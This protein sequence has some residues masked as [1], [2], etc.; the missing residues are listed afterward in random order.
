MGDSDKPSYDME[1]TGDEAKIPNYGDGETLYERLGGIY[2]IAG[3][4]DVL[5][6]R[7]FEND[8]ANQ[9]PITAEFHET[10]DP[11]GFKYLVTA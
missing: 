3:A 6:E 10:H 2:G 4:V 1:P 11:A 8:T 7:L 9:N 5:T